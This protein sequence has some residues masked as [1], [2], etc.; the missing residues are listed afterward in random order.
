MVVKANKPTPV[1]EDPNALIPQKPIP[2]EK[3]PHRNNKT[4]HKKMNTRIK[5]ELLDDLKIR[6]GI[7]LGLPPVAKADDEKT[8]EEFAKKIGV[9]M[10]TLI[11]WKYDALVQDTARNALRMFGDDRKLQII[12]KIMDQA[13]AGEWQQQRLFM[14]WM[15]EIGI[16]AKDKFKR[17]PPQ[18]E[19]TL[20]TEQPKGE[21]QPDAGEQPETDIDI[22]SLPDSGGVH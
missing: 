20:V 3:I 13:A 19:V 18:M 2:L 17:A 21:E 14:E 15:G 4:N 16:N 10:V 6:Y 1:C 8:I 5:N 11:R 7:W 12:N 22:E 9:S